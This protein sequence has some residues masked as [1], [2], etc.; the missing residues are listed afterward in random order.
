MVT[1]LGKTCN[2][3]NSNSFVKYK[4]IIKKPCK[5]NSSSFIS[6]SGN[7]WTT[8]VRPMRFG[9]QTDHNSPTHYIYNIVCKTI[10]NIKIWNIKPTVNNL[11][12]TDCVLT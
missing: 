1:D 2:F 7:E 6:D 9:T 5:K 3:C 10:S 11:M 8:H 4:I 12:Y